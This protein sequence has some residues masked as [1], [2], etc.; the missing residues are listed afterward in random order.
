MVLAAGSFFGPVAC[1]LFRVKD[2]LSITSSLDRDRGFIAKYRHADVSHLIFSCRPNRLMVRP[3][4]FS[5][6]RS[7]LVIFSPDPSVRHNLHR[8]ELGLAMA[9]KKPIKIG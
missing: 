5:L 9:L 6:T 3:R 2:S 1:C 7:R 4:A 8:V